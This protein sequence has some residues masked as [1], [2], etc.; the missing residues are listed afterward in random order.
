VTF[1][2]LEIIWFLGK[3]GGGIEGGGV[4]VVGVL[5]RGGWGVKGV[6]GVGREKVY[7]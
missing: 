2:C 5:G 4:V 1:C 3:S 7:E 6:E